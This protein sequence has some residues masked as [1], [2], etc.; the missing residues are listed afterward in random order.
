MDK[1]SKIV[2]IYFVKCRKLIPRSQAVSPFSGGKKCQDV[3]NFRPTC[4]RKSL[5]TVGG[6][7][8]NPRELKMMPSL[9]IHGSSQQVPGFFRNRMFLQPPN[10]RQWQ[11]KPA[12]SNEI[13][14][15][16]CGQN[17]FIL[18]AYETY[19]MYLLYTYTYNATYHIYI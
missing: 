2:D 7:Y 1:C 3:A 15:G 13:F 5:A 10:Q 9:V 4:S 17:R 8:K 11:Q 6:V 19:D 12:D 14:V 16:E 18:V